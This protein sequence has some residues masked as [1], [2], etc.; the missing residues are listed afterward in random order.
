MQ[1]SLRAAH[2]VKLL[3]FGN[4]CICIYSFWIV[5]VASERVADHGSA[6]QSFNLVHAGG[7]KYTTAIFI[8]FDLPIRLF[9][10]P[11]G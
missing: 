4:S 7:D 1:V 8:S 6:L 3:L 11:V 5:D 10:Q 9:V 2:R